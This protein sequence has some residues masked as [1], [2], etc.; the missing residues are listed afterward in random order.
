MTNPNR[1]IP[2][3]ATVS[4]WTAPDGWPLRRFD[5]P[6]TRARG[7]MVVQGGRGDIFEKHLESFAHW[8][9]AG[10]SIVAFD[11]RGHGGSGRPACDLARGEFATAVADLAAIWRTLPRDR[12][13]ILLG[14]SMGGFLALRAAVEAAVDPDA[15][16]LVAPML[17][18]R[19]PFGRFSAPVARFL[20][21]RGD[22]ARQA[23]KANERPHS[24]VG[25]QALL[26]TDLGRYED[27]LWWHAQ[28]PDHAPKPPSWAWLAEAFEATA[29]LASDPRLGSLRPPVLMLLADRDGLVDA[30]AAVK[31]AARLR[32]VTLLR[33]GRESAHEILREADPVR[34]RALAAIDAFLDSH[35]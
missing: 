18:L 12:P 16:I 15:L 27:E 2:P 30:R 33:F 31:V 3:D 14:H 7:T 4:R 17:G 29:T 10:W 11:W 13:R 25:R 34:D 28:S 23:W 35:A 20:R 21:D 6:A 5:W 22:P 26:T 32:D 9:A 1:I 24:R 19:S 8:H